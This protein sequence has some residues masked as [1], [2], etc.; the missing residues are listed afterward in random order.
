MQGFA[1][2]AAT[3]SLHR[4]KITRRQTA[5]RKLPA[6]APSQEPEQGIAKAMCPAAAAP[7]T[8]FPILIFSKSHDF[9]H[10]VKRHPPSPDNGAP[11]HTLPQQTAR[12]AKHCSRAVMIL[13]GLSAQPGAKAPLATLPCNGGQHSIPRF[14]QI[15][16]QELTIFTIQLPLLGFR[17]Q[18]QREDNDQNGRTIS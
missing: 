17:Q 15:K 8:Q 13:S 18:K 12:K 5:T 11:R 14:F 10:D 4:A 9:V 1:G 3:R 6:L 16:Q 2:E 7:G